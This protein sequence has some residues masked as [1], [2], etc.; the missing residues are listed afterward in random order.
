[1]NKGQLSSLD[2]LAAVFLFFTVVVFFNA[3]WSA[4]SVGSQEALE[5]ARLSQTAFRVSSALAE[6]QGTPWNWEETPSQAKAIGLVDRPNELSYAKALALASRSYNSTKRMLGV[7][8]ELKVEGRYANG[9]TAF[10][11]GNLNG[12][13]RAASVKRFYWDGTEK[14]TLIVSVGR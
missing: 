9:S 3:A 1:M 10:S 4:V 2:A 6:S 12:T 11:F 13:L 14:G 7:N 5:N 8:G